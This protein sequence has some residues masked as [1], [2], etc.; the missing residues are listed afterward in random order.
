[1]KFSEIILLL[2]TDNFWITVDDDSENTIHLEGQ[3]KETYI[4]LV[5]FCKYTVE[6]ITPIN[7]GL[8]IDLRSKNDKF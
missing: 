4:K 8:E 5:D 2:N 1:M 6:R 7:N 3:T